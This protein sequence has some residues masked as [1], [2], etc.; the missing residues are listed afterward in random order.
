[1]LEIILHTGNFLNAGNNRLGAALGFHLDTLSKLHDTKTSDNKQTIF[2]VIIQ[3]I[4]DQRPDLINFR[5]EDNE[6][7]EAGARVSLQTVEAELNKL[8]KDFDVVSALSPTINTVD[9]DDLFVKRFDE[10]TVKAKQDLSILEEK[11]QKANKTY[12]EVVQ[13]FAEDP[14]VM[15]PEEF[16]N[17]WKNFV[18]RTIET[19]ERIDVEK[20]KR[21]KERKREEQKLK[22]EQEIANKLAN[23]GTTEAGPA[24]GGDASGGDG[25]RGGRAPRG[26]RTPQGRGG[27]GAG[28]SNPSEVTDLF[29]KLQGSKKT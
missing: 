16:F 8:V 4:K 24:T 13:L 6:L 23:V 7:L 9:S 28:G 17:V 12:Q 18:S 15:G 21:D 14:K 22:R 20:E 29:A 10:F 25:G 26:G 3:M 27:R 2:E 19:S 11:F 1:M 5:K